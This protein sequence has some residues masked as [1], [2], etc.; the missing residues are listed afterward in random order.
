MFLSS[1]LGSRCENMRFPKKA[2][3]GDIYYNV[4]NRRNNWL[5]TFEVWNFAI[6]CQFYHGIYEFEQWFKKKQ[7]WESSLPSFADRFY[8]LLICLD[9]W[10]VLITDMFDY[11]FV[12]IIHMS[13]LLICFDY[14]YVF[15]VCLIPVKIENWSPT[16]LNYANNLFNFIFIKPLRFAVFKSFYSKLCT[17]TER[18]T[19]PCYCIF[20]YIKLVAIFFNMWKPYPI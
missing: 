15:K 17:K 19:F 14:W 6:F 20:W 9:Y 11:W 5:F 3:F 7:Y 16:I 4:F 8:W 1:L 2:H 12:L 13:W 10:Y 18:S